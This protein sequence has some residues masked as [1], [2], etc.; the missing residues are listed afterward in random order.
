M[1]S[2]PALGASISVMMRAR[3]DLPQ[4][5]SPTMASVLPFSTEKETPFTACT[6][7]AGRNMPPPTW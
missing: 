6:V 2:S 3:V 4:P 5:D 7:R 1:N